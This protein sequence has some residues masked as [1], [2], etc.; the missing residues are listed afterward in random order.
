MIFGCLHNFFV[1][2]AHKDVADFAA[3]LW[4]SLLISFNLMPLFA[5][6]KIDF[7]VLKIFYLVL[8]LM[9]FQ[10]NNKFFFSD[11]KIS[12]VIKE[13]LE[14]PLSEKQ[15]YGRLAIFVAIESIMVPVVGGFLRLWL[16]G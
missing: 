12:L 8:V 9:I 4:I 13:Y 6:V 7:Q 14:L 16:R 11:Q 1:N 10:L 15:F 5:W 2:S 3:R